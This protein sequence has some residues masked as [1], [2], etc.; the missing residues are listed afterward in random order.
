MGIGLAGEF[1]SAG[2]R[3]RRVFR[4]YDHLQ[5]ADDMVVFSRDRSLCDGAASQGTACATSLPGDWLSCY[6]DS[7]LPLLRVY[8]VQFH[9]LRHEPE[10]CGAVGGGSRSVGRRTDLWLH[11]E[12]ELTLTR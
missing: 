3:M 4:R 11:T 6:A 8:A 12:V 9:R 1:E 2:D 10:A 7:L 5:R